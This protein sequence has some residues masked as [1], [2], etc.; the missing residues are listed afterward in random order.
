MD[1]VEFLFCL[2][3]LKACQRIFY[4]CNNSYSMYSSFVSYW[5]PAP[6]KQWSLYMCGF[7]SMYLIYVYLNIGYGTRGKYQH[8]TTYQSLERRAFIN[9]FALRMTKTRWSFVP[10]ECNRVKYMNLFC[11]FGFLYRNIL[12]VFLGYL[13]ISAHCFFNER[14]D[15]TLSGNPHDYS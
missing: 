9:P 15:R 13:F 5:V 12:L 2:I 1:S 6:C 10:S 4:L 8:P 7:A 11:C 14:H 3:S